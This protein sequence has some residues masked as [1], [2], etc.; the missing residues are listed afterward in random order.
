MKIKEYWDTSYKELLRHQTEY[1]P[2][3]SNE[4]V[5]KYDADHVT[6]VTAIV[7]AVLPMWGATW[8]F[9]WEN[10]YIK[11][12]WLIYV[13]LFLYEAV[14]L[15]VYYRVRMQ[16]SYRIES[17]G[18]RTVMEN[19][20]E[21]EFYDY[22]LLREAVIKGKYKYK[23]DELAIYNGKFQ[24]CFPYE[25]GDSKAFEKVLTRYHAIRRLS[26]AD[27]PILDKEMI[28][29]MDRKYYHRNMINTLLLTWLVLEICA[30]LMS[31]A[32]FSKMVILYFSVALV[33]Y[34]GSFGVL[35]ELLQSMMHIRIV[36]KEM[37][38]KYGDKT[39]DGFINRHITVVTVF[40]CIIMMG[41]GFGCV[42][43]LSRIL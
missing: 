2:A 34:L 10:T 11:L 6:I 39:K 29:F 12:G 5:A 28:R 16:T 9:K 30:V 23:K 32:A 40:R 33:F 3:M 37:I 17:G 13:L 18:L 27:L 26:G 35:W 24:I 4:K 7:F 22:E 15:T 8:F 38:F 25:R 42:L 36:N 19:G 1:L 43:L 31:F 14:F 21:G 20:S 41:I